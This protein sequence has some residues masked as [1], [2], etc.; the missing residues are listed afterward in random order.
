MCEYV[1]I[2]RTKYFRG[3][4]VHGDWDVRV[5]QAEYRELSVVA[6]SETGVLVSMTVQRNGTKVARS[7]PPPFHLGPTLAMPPS[8]N[9]FQRR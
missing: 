7:V 6:N 3:R 5:E 4:R 1:A 9:W 2:R 8:I